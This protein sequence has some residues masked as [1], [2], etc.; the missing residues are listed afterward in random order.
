M[1]TTTVCFEIWNIPWM[2]DRH[3]QAERWQ[4]TL[5]RCIF[6]SIKVWP[7]QKMNRLILEHRAI[8][9]KLL[10]SRIFWIVTKLIMWDHFWNYWLDN[11][12]KVWHERFVLSKST[13]LWLLCE[14]NRRKLGGMR[15]YNLLMA[16]HCLYWS[17]L[18]ESYSLTQVAAQDGARKR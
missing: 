2:I 11:A 9:W 5:T 1:L 4:P 13:L 7:V 15:K 10:V 17:W 6:G 14:Y 12:N 18:E 8:N 3:G 16:N